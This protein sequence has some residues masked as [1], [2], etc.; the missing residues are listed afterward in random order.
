MGSH[1]CAVFIFWWLLPK[2]SRS[3]QGGDPPYPSV[4]HL[5]MYSQWVVGEHTPKLE[6]S[7]DAGGFRDSAFDGP[8]YDH[9][10]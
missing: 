1:A 7:G 5:H 3:F 2:M 4:R 9:A 10:F 8:V 6:R